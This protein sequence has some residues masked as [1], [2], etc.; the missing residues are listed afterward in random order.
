MHHSHDFRPV[1]RALARSA[2][3]ITFR[4]IAAKAGYSQSC[5]TPTAGTGQPNVL[6]AQYDNAR[7]GYS[8][9]ESILT[10]ATLGSTVAIC[11]PS[12]SPLL[13]DTSD[14]PTDHRAATLRQRNHRRFAGDYIE[15]RDKL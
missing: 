10:S 2:I 15:L 8:P 11:T 1:P 9:S 12:W 6:T 7:D 5:P 14:L 4:L 3:A 13:V